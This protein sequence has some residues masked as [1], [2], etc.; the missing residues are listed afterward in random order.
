M[1]IG[2]LRLAGVSVAVLVIQLGIAG[3]IAAKYLYQRWRCPRVWTRST[4]YDP[5]L[6]MRGRYLSLQV[7]V[8]GCES[9]LPP[10]AEVDFPRNP[11]GTVASPNFTV[12]GSKVAELQ[13]R[14]AVSFSARLEV[15]NNRLLAFRL[16]N[17]GDARNGQY[18]TA[19][20]GTVCDAMHL[21]EPVNFYVAE[22]ASTPLPLKAGE[23]LWMELTVPPKGPPRPLQLAVKRGSQ[24]MPLAYQ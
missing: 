1:R 19:G 18:V 23:E 17:E 16:P 4:A 8:D 6:P 20:P 15:K 14:L 21:S 9:T 2:S 7:M 11:D 24:W 10:D 13:T 5:S 22:H 12:R 3:S